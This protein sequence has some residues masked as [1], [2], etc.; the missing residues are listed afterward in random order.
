MVVHTVSGFPTVPCNSVCVSV[1]ALMPLSLPLRYVSPPYTVLF[2]SVS[3]HRAGSVSYLRIGSNTKPRNKKIKHSEH[4]CAGDSMGARI[5]T[6][7]RCHPEHRNF[8]DVKDHDCANEVLDEKSQTRRRTARS[9]SQCCQH[10]R[11]EQTTVG[12]ENETIV[13]AGGRPCNNACVEQWMSL[14]QF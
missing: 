2:G 3:L 7:K 1:S 6:C 9:S 11:L 13:H 14:L 5:C 8:G 12:T 10:T 4:T